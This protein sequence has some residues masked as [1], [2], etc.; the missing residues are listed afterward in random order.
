LR[1]IKLI[2]IDALSYFTDEFLREFIMNELKLVR[3]RDI[4]I[5]DEETQEFSKYWRTK[6][7]A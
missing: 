2:A 4:K 6:V 3:P 1:K 5:Y 7:A